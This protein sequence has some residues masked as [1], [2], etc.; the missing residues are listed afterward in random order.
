MA[1]TVLLNN[2]DHSDLRIITSRSAEYGDDVMFA[3]TFPAEFRSIQAH[4]PIVFHKSAEGQFQP[5]ALFGFRDRENLF[6][7]PRG[8]DAGYVPLT[9]ERQPFLI[10][11]SGAQIMMHVDLDNPRVSR[12]QGEPLFREHGGTTDFLQR[13]SSVLLAIHEGL[14]SSPAFVA[15]LTELGLLESFVLDVQHEDGSQSRL[16]GF[17]TIH[18][19]HLNRLDGAALERLHKA[20]HLQAIYMSMAS[21][22][23]FPALIERQ[24]RVHAGDR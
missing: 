9:I 22:S 18:E 15:T 23:N 12:T 24:K 5:V 7:G 2:I 3:V 21:L 16:A 1:N 20:G 11:R 13:M 4:Y 8:W 17:Y 14:Q 10:G 19:E 6:L